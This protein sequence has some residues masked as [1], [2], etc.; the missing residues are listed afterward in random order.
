MHMNTAPFLV[1]QVL[2]TPSTVLPYRWV[3]MQFS[4]CVWLFYYTRHPIIAN[5]IYLPFQLFALH[6]YSDFAKWILYT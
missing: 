4:L 2:R 3:F 6:I 1:H 5:L